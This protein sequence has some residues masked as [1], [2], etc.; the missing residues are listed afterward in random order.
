MVCI[1]QKKGENGHADGSLILFFAK[2]S[3]LFM[4]MRSVNMDLFIVISAGCMIFMTAF[5]VLILGS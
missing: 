1:K 5:A 4:E 3:P 2:Y